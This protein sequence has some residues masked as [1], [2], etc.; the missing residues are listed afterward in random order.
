MEFTNHTG[1]KRDEAKLRTCKLV[2]WWDLNKVVAYSMTA[3]YTA[4][5][6]LKFKF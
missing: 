5:Y 4:D 1:N 6:F 3:L 2:K